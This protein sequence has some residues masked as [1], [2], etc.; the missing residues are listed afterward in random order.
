[1]REAL[2]QRIAD[3]KRA[4]V[5]ATS[6]ARPGG[7]RG[8][9]VT[10]EQVDDWVEEERE[11]L[12]PIVVAHLTN[13]DRIVLLSVG[14]EMAIGDFCVK[15]GVSASTA[16]RWRR[17]VMKKY[18]VNTMKEAYTLAYTRGDIRKQQGKQRIVKPERLTPE[19]ECDLLIAEQEE[20]T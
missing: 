20:L 1:M 16:K 14:K 17:D 5:P 12:P 13:L 18:G 15:Y 11:T 8:K 19:M 7:G 3:L 4:R 10:K 6:L 2:R 9:T